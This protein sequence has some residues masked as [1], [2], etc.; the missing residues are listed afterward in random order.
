MA[1]LLL[2]L[3]FA[4]SAEYAYAS[5]QNS[6]ICAFIAATNIATVVSDKYSCSIS[7][8]PNTDPCSNSWPDLV[9]RG[10]DIIEISVSSPGLNGTLLNGLNG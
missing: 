4:V 1:F 3:C 8:I 10:S 9:C 5:N 7:G 6:G 2:I